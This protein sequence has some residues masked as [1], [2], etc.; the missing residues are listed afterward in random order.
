MENKILTEEEFEKLFSLEPTEEDFFE[1]IETE[2]TE[3]MLQANYEA[4]MEAMLE[5]D[6]VQDEINIKELEFVRENISYPVDNFELD[7]MDYWKHEGYVDVEELVGYKSGSYPSYKFYKE[8][9]NPKSLTYMRQDDEENGYHSMVW[10]T[11][12]YCGDDYSGYLLFPLTNGKY[13]KISYSC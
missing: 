1:E 8:K 3:E 10:Q 12:G 13:W 4:A 11:V 2:Y 6:R 7:E 9:D 5:M